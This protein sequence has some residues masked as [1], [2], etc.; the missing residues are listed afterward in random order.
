MQFQQLV[1]PHVDAAYNLARHLLREEADARDAV[2]ESLM[3]AWQYFGAFRG[4][5]ALP[6]LLQIVRNTAFTFLQRKHPQQALNEEWL[7]DHPSN[8]SDPSVE[9]IERADGETVRQ[10]VAQLPPIYREVI[11]LRELE[12]L[13]YKEIASVTG[14]NLGTVMSRISR[15]RRQL[16]SS[17]QAYAGKESHHDL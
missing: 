3:K 6:W 17:L 16:Q 2:Q 9:L 4:T 15:A 7:D 8:T 1:L 11:V 5:T 14:T 12:G 10:A 13:S